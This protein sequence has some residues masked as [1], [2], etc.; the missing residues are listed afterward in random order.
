[1][2]GTGVTRVSENAHV[3][4]TSN[5]PPYTNSNLSSILCKATSNVS[6]KYN[7]A[8][9]VVEISNDRNQLLKHN[10][11]DKNGTK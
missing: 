8:I 1:M 7:K 3:P 4:V 9:M 2:E 10:R 5:L 6:C 11:S